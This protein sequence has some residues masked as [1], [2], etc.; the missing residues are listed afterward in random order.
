MKIDVFFDPICP[1]CYIGAKRLEQSLALY[2]KQRADASKTSKKKASEQ[3]DIYWRMFQLNPSMPK[4]GMLRADYLRAK[5]GSPA[6]YHQVYHP[7][8]QT[9]DK[10]NIPLNLDRIKVTPS[11]LEAH[12]LVK[13]TARTHNSDVTHKLVNRLFEAYFIDGADIGDSAVL[14]GLAAEL[15]IKSSDDSSQSDLETLKQDQTDAATYQISGVPYMV[16]N[17]SY[18][19]SGAQPPHVLIP[20]LELAAQNTP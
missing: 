15:M 9:A 18:S 19:V 8:Q 11:T 16:F 1:W 7:I 17:D 6:V 4:S 20:M 10:E 13:H 12:R 2:Q 3:I 5:F 14:S